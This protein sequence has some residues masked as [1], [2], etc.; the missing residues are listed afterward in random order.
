MRGEN[1]HHDR[2]GKRQG[3]DQKPRKTWAIMHAHGSESRFT[4]GTD[5]LAV[6]LQRNTQISAQVKISRNH[7]PTII[8]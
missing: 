6:T 4:A 1:P 3:R 2:T 7:F 5:N 8:I